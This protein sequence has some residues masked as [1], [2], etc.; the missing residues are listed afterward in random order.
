MVDARRPTLRYRHRIGT[1]K[2]QVTGIEQQP[3]LI[4]GMAHQI[5]NVLL[6][7]D[8]GPHVVVIGNFDSLAQGVAGKFG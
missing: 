4:A 7:F 6:G 8:D 2:G 1:R 3:D 5:I